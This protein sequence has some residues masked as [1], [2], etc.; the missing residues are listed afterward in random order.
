VGHVAVTAG[1]LGAIVRE[2]GD[3]RFRMLSNNHVLANEDLAK[4]GDEILQPGS[5]DHGVSPADVCAHLES[6]I[7]LKPSGNLVDAA[8]AL[9]AE[10]IGG[11]PTALTGLG[12]L[13]GV[14]TQPL[15]D[16]E[17]VYKVG[18]TTQ[19]TEGRVSAFDVDNLPVE[20]DRGVITFDQQIEI[21]PVPGAGPFSLG[22]DSGSLIVDEELRAVGL[23]FAGNDLDVTYANPI[24][25]VLALLG[26]EIVS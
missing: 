8:I 5:F 2:P 25:T 3:D 22:G 24:S 7:A 20:F 17:R 4:S 10:G 23:L 13:A 18:R 16:E 26:V 19:L 15:A 11:D 9:V 12:R 6:A 14:R 1:T 21:S